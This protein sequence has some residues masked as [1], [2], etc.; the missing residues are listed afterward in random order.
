MI[1]HNSNYKHTF[2]VDLSSSPILSPPR[3]FISPSSPI[4]L[5]G[6]DS[7]NPSI[8]LHPTPSSGITSIN[9]HPFPPL[10]P[11]PTLSLSSPILPPTRPSIPPSSFS[12]QIAAIPASYIP[13]NHYLSS[14]EAPPTAASESLIFKFYV[15]SLPA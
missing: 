2:L 7:Y 11:A 9:T 3:P 8:L 12:A 5:L 10:S 4:P 6:P 1:N 13:H 15:G 14:T